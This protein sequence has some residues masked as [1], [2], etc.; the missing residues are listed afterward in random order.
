MMELCAQI[1]NERV[2]WNDED[3][4]QNGTGTDQEPIEQVSK[5][6]KKTC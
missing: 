5:I 2:K 6:N 4:N 3:R 1:M